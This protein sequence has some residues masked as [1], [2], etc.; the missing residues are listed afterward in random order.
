MGAGLTPIDAVPCD[1]IA[2]RR[3]LFVMATT[4]EYRDALA[5]RIR[6]LVTGVGPVEAALAV[7]AA[8]ARMATRGALPDLVVSLGSAG[9]RAGVLGRVYQ[10]A[11]VAWRDVDASAIGVARGLTPFLDEG[12]TIALP[13]PLDLPCATLSTGADVVTGAGYARIDAALVDMESWAVARACRRFGVAMIGWRGVSDGPGT[14]DGAADEGLAGWTALLPVLDRG[15]ADAVER[16]AHLSPA[17]WDAL[18]P[19]RGE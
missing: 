13:T 5:A 1:I 6:P 8:L 17:D 16:L 3:V 14:L 9:S 7:G 15:L 11:S 4:H 2:G 10:V 19:D 12:A 18:L